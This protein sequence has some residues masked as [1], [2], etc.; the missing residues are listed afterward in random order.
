MRAAPTLSVESGTNYY[1]LY[2][3]GGSDSFDGFSSEYV[4]TE[5]MS[6]FRN[7]QVSGTAGQAGILRTYNS[8]AKVEMS[9]EL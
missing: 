9:A 4:S 5:Q 1:I 7:S 8:S 3:D 2:R 6:C